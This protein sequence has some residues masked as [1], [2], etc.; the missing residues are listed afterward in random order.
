MTPRQYI[1]ELRCQRHLTQRQLAERA[2]IDFSYLPKIENNR[3]KHTPPIKTLQDLA[4]A[5]E[6]D[7]LELIRLADRVPSIPQTIHSYRER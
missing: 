4:M 2:C 5:P 3:L 6:V 7:D 1:K